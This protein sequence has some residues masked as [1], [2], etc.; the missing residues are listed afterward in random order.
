[1]I[2]SERIKLYL[3][4][5]N[6]CEQEEGRGNVKE[7]PFGIKRFNYLFNEFLLLKNIQYFKII[8]LA[9]T[10]ADRVKKFI[11][12]CPNGLMRLTMGAEGGICGKGSCKSPLNVS[13]P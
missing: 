6:F 13:G 3:A 8:L 12:N 1:M 9:S 7:Y 5:L 11:V 10:L 2:T 4:K